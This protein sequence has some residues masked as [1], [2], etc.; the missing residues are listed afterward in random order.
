MNKD[1]TNP[2][3]QHRELF[4]TM[5]VTLADSGVTPHQLYC[6]GRA[7]E[8][9]GDAIERTADDPAY[10]V[11]PM[12]SL[13]IDQEANLDECGD[14]LIWEYGEIRQA[15]QVMYPPISGT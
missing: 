6:W 15:A 10:P 1:A 8:L 5:L 4:D 12:D 3:E 2:Y 13:E 11:T 14:H 9:A 7:A